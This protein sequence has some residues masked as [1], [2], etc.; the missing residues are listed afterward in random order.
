M[1][2]KHIHQCRLKEHCRIKESLTPDAF[3]LIDWDAMDDATHTQSDMFNLCM[4]KQIGGFCGVG[5]M[6]KQWG[7][8]EDSKCHSC[9]EVSEADAEHILYCPHLDRVDSCWLV[10]VKGL[11]EWMTMQY[12]P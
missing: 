8:W 3:D 6:M 11:E 7:F 10:A 4:M 2:L 12:A 9:D 5:K 1:V